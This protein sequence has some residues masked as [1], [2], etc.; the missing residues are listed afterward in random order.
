MSQ[1]PPQPSHQ[2]HSQR[3][4]SLL[5]MPKTVAEYNSLL[6]LANLHQGAFEEVRPSHGN[7]A[8]EFSALNALMHDR[9]A[10]WSKQA[11]AIK[12]D[13]EFKAIE[14]ERGRVAKDLHDEVL[15]LLARLIRSIQSRD[16]QQTEVELVKEL[17]NTVAAFRDLLGELHPVDLEELGLVAA[18]NNLCKRYARLTER[19][20]LF[21][22]HEEEC[23]LSSFQQLCIYRA[24]QLALDLFARSDNDILLM[25]Y[26]RS[27][28]A[29]LIAVRCIDKSVSSA[30]WLSDKTQDFDVFESWCDMAGAEVE[31]ATKGTGGFPYD[32]IVSAPESE[33]P[34]EDMVTMLGLLTQARLRE[35]DSIVALAQ[36][37]WAELINRDCTL[38]K[39]LAIV[40]ERKRICDVIS[41]LIMPRLMRVSEL[42]DRVDDDLIR[43]DVNERMKV[44]QAAVSGVMSELHARLLD[45]AG[46]MP[47]I[48][49]LVE[50]FKRA[51]LIETTIISNVLADKLNIPREAKFA[52]YRVT[53]EALN[54]I[55]KHS[56]ATCAQVRVEQDGDG[57]RVCIEDN[58]GGFQGTKNI[59]SR[60]LKN[61]RQR[62]SE[63]G[64]S[65]AWEPAKSFA[66]GTLL[67][68]SLC[69]AASI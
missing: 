2:P 62:A 4:L 51:S 43:V 38:F 65:V 5:T 57:L 50:R 64:A 55:E 7:S 26:Y 53:Q 20:I 40:A 10:R 63:I 36:E 9:S 22:E 27:D 19:C 25:D 56:G 15:P 68:I 14:Q 33:P 13:I 58:G 49:T 52:I 18:L 37:Q 32:F 24:I 21:N 47:S 60:G 46:L 41:K 69:E 8:E 48:R 39:N 45:E 44:I 67:T 35:L 31:T 54:N 30:N 3:H 59:M 29:C 6:S 61:I 1:S 12:F 23:N 11:R 28:Q 42:S 16:T 34:K 17:H 66:T